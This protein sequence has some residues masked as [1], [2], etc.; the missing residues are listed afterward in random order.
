MSLRNFDLVVYGATGFTG[1]EVCFHL[2]QKNDPHLRWA[3]AGRSKERLQTLCG[4]IERLSTRGVWAFDKA[5]SLPDGILVG[6]ISDEAGLRT[7]VTSKT[8][9]LLNCTGPYRFLGEQVVSACIAT[10]TDYLDLC[11]EPEFMDRMFLK[12]NEA[13]RE[14]EVFVVHAC[15]FDSV[16]ADLGVLYTATEGFKSPAIC[17][18]VESFLTVSSGKSGVHGHLTTFEAAVHGVYERITLAGMSP[19]HS[20]SYIH[21]HARCLT[22][23]SAR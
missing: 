19:M 10:S 1:R 2:A 15:A 9:C 14:A 13:A 23:G 7:N 11:G 18:S 20:S 21:V 3:V 16:P 8:R 22:Q 12:Y 6:D 5:L 17:T 4:E